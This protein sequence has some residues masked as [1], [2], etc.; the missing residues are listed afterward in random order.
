[1]NPIHD[2]VLLCITILIVTDWFSSLPCFFARHRPGGT[3][4]VTRALPESRHAAT[5]SGAETQGHGAATSGV[6]WGRNPG[7]TGG[8]WRERWILIVNICEPLS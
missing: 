4:Q 5:A 8:R 6:E 2:Y 3:A 7:A 1:M